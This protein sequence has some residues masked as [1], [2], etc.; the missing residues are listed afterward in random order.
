MNTLVKLAVVLLPATVLLSAVLCYSLVRRTLRPVSRMTR[1]AREI[2]E[3]RD[4]SRRIGIEGGRDEISTLAETFDTMLEQLQ[5]SFEQQKQFTSD[6]SHELRTPMTVILS[7]CDYLLADPELSGKDREAIQIIREK[8]KN[9]T[10]LISQLLLLSRA[11]RT[12][13]MAPRA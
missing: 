12:I 1:T 13:S 7:Q 3:K 8:A 4:L 11:D 6:V 9:L 2:Y 10:R 5:A